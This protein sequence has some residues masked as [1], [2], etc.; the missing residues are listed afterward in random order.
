MALEKA[1]GQRGQS[2]E[3]GEDG[4]RTARRI[5]RASRKGP[6]ATFACGHCS[7]CESICFTSPAAQKRLRTRS[8]VSRFVR[9]DTCGARDS[10]RGCA[11]WMDAEARDECALAQ[12][13]SVCSPRERATASVFIQIA[14]PLPDSVRP[15]GEVM[16]KGDADAQPKQMRSKPSLLS[17]HRVASCSADKRRPQPRGV[18]AWAEAPAWPSRRANP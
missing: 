13:T 14:Q 2:T 5:A 12:E 4:K 6:H 7:S 11:L 10:T 9:T 16:N 1:R 17:R 18:S 15:V 3:H 8:A